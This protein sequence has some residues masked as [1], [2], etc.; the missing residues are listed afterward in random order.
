MLASFTTSLSLP[1]GPAGVH[2]LVQFWQQMLQDSKCIWWLLASAVVYGGQ[3]HQ[4]DITNNGTCNF[5]RWTSQTMSPDGHHKQW[6]RQFHQMDITNNLTWWTSQTMVQANAPLHLNINCY[7][8][9]QRVGVLAGGSSRP[10]PPCAS[11][12]SHRVTLLSK[13]HGGWVCLGCT[14]PLDAPPAH[15][16]RSI[17]WLCWADGKAVVFQSVDFLFLAQQAC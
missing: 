10:M 16:V 9:E 5:T 7:T 11:F 15:H 12:W 13:Q 3:C 14:T 8:Q 4:M 17:P 2:F 1:I 6:Y